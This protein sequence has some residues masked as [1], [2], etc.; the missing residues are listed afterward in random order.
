[1][2][3][4]LHDGSVVSFT[5]AEL[6]ST[7]TRLTNTNQSYCL[8]VQ[9]T[10]HVRVGPNLLVMDVGWI[11]GRKL[12]EAYSISYDSTFPFTLR[13]TL[14]QS[15]YNINQALAGAG[16]VGV[17]S[18]SS[19]SQVYMGMYSG[20]AQTY[21]EAGQLVKS[22]GVFQGAAAELKSLTAGA[23]I[24]LTEGA[25]AITIDGGSTLTATLPLSIS[26]G[27]ISIDLSPY[28]TNTDLGTKQ[29]TLT[30]NAPISL[31]ATTS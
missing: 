9:D 21:L 4:T 6:A 13:F 31:V 8:G 10:A 3:L 15:H 24:T 14:G 1:M 5:N 20:A 16:Y 7:L 26:S 18:V 28:A 17:S 23:G 2:N 22:Q 27:V 12:I 11:T 25:D 29:D 30:V 19:L